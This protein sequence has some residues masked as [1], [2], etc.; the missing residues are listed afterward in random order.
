[1][2]CDIVIFLDGN[3]PMYMKWDVKQIPALN[4]SINVN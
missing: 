4:I 3:F 2:I 1:M